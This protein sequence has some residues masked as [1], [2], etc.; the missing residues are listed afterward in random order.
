MTPTATFSRVEALA[1]FCAV[2]VT[3]NIMFNVIDNGNGSFTV[4]MTGY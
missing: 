1:E 3:K 2:L 4:H